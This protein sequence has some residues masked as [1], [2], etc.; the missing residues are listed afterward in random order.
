MDLSS[1]NLE[2]TKSTHSLSL[3]HLGR[4]IL[5]PAYGAVLLDMGASLKDL[6]QQDVEV[7]ALHQHPAEQ[8]GQREMQEDGHSL[9]C[10]LFGR[11]DRH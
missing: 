9:A 11:K 8:G 3:H 1:T 5:T 4:S 10:P 7:E 6:D 2:C